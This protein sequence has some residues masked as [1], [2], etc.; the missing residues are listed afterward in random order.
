VHTGLGRALT[1]RFLLRSD[2]TIIAGVRRLEDQT[3]QS[4]SELPRGVNSKLITVVID[5]TSDTDALEAIQ[6]VQNEHGVKKLDIVVANAGY[7]TVF[8]DLSQVKPTEV[9]DLFDI[10]TIGKRGLR[11]H[12][13]F[14]MLMQMWQ[15]HFVSFRL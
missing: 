13:K 14:C 2:T 5:S 7:G 6:L 1:S 3:T 8:G 9:R 10:N 11:S 12:H 15:D 4:L